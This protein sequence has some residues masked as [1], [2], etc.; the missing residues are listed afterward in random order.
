MQFDTPSGHEGFLT[1]CF[2]IIF[3]TSSTDTCI[4]RTPSVNSTGI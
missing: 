1:S 2:S 4:S 3:L